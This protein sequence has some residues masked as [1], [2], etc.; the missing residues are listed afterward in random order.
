MIC[1]VSFKQ[2]SHAFSVFNIQLSPIFTVL[3]T[4][5]FQTS[6]MKHY[7]FPAVDKL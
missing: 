2:Q 3:Q 6:L 5:K 7:L 4:N 1:R